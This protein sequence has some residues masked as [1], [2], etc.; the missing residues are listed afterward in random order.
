[1]AQVR[2]GLSKAPLTVR[3]TEECRRED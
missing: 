1:M 3:A 2:R